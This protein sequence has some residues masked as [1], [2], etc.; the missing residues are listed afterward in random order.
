MSK[1]TSVKFSIFQWLIGNKKKYCESCNQIQY[2]SY[3]QLR[4]Y[5]CKCGANKV[6]DYFIE[7]YKGIMSKQTAEIDID[8]IKVYLVHHVQEVKH[9]K[10]IG[11]NELMNYHEGIVF[12]IENVL[13]IKL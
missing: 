5:T 6:M 9:F 3:D 2:H 13:K 8:K 12:F 7:K 10:N 1:E 11:N 4:G